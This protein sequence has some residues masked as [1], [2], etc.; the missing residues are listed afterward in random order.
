MANAAKKGFDPTIQGMVT[1]SDKIKNTTSATERA[2]LESDIFGRQWSKAADLLSKGGDAF[3]TEA[4][5]VNQNI[6][7]TQKQIDQARNLEFALHDLNEAWEGIVTILSFGLIPG[8]TKAITSIDLLIGAEND[9]TAA[10]VLNARIQRGLGDP[11]ARAKALQAQG[12]A[13]LANAAA[14]AS[15][16]TAMQDY[17]T[18]FDNANAANWDVHSSSMAVGSDLLNNT[19][20]SYKDA[21]AAQASADATK[22]RATAQQAEADAIQNT[23]SVAAGGMPSVQSKIKALQDEIKNMP[24]VP[25][26]EWAQK[27]IDTIGNNL[28]TKNISPQKAQEATANI[29]KALQAGITANAQGKP[30]SVPAALNFVKLTAEGTSK[31]GASVISAITDGTAIPP[32]PVKVDLNAEPTAQ[33]TL[34]WQHYQAMQ[35]KTVKIIQQIVTKYPGTGHA[36]GADFIVPPGFPNDSFPMRVQSGERVTVTPANQVNN[37]QQYNLNINSNAP[38]TGA[39]Q[40]FSILKS[41]SSVGV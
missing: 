16:T 2:T 23:L 39:I 27:S 7:L 21:A 5:A 12:L 41:L 32:A 35:N 6:V 38:T 40:E 18:A 15:N 33:F 24:L 14:I 4:D 11:D 19:E 36:G 17:I 26:E 22:A 29:Q 3:Q 8:V 9:Q 20:Q 28:A 31:G 37:N 13:Y 34:G 25:L 10:M 1:L 30:V